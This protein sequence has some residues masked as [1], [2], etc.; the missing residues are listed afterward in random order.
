[1]KKGGWVC[2]MEWNQYVGG[3]L[4]AAASG[5]MSYFAD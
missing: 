3:A 2:V 1:M 4:P 5:G